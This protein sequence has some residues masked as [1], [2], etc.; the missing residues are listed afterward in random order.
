ME[1]EDIWEKTKEGLRYASLAQQEPNESLGITPEYNKENRDKLWDS[2]ERKKEYKGSVFGDKKTYEDP[3]SGKTLHS[4][5]KAA[6]RKYHMYNTEGD[7]CSTEWASHSSETDHI[8]S[9]KATHNIAKYNPYLTDQDFKEIMNSD[10][11][12]RVLSK[13]FNTSKG[14]KSDWQVITDKNNGLTLNGRMQMAKE[15][16]CADASLFAKFTARTGKNIGTEFVTESKDDLAVDAIYVTVEAVDKLCKVS[17][18]EVTL[19]DA[20][21]DVG[22]G[23]VKKKVNEEKNRILVNS[24]NTG[25]KCSKN[26]ALKNLAGCNYLSEIVA[27]GKIVADSVVKYVNGELDENG[28]VEEVVKSGTVMVVGMMGAKIG[29]AIGATVGG[30]PGELIGE[31]LGTIITTVACGA[32]V[33]VFENYKGLDNYKLKESQIRRL[34]SEALKEMENQRNK[35]RSLIEREYKHWD[36]EIQSGFDMMLSNA[37]EATFNIQGVTEGL[38]RILAVF[39]KGV[40]FKSIEE[41]EAQLDMPLRLG[42]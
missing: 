18:G 34:E 20:T 31:A 30:L 19:V 10:A 4:S 35:F 42:F 39:G 11:N 27:V 36:D 25:L 12:Y 3:I 32:V 14:D 6:Q 17:T 13:K 7:K 15:K 16:V 9:L 37:C 24:V 29:G 33:S 38:D 22:V 5:Q 21:M 2:Q 8:N 28:V 23:Y 41:Y 1:N 40:R 26:Q